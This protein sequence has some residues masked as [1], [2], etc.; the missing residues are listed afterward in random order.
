MDAEKDSSRISPERH[1]GRRELTFCLSGDDDKQKYV[2]NA[3]HRIVKKLV[4]ILDRRS[5]QTGEERNP[6]KNITAETQRAQE[7]HFL[8]VGRRDNKNI[9]PPGQ[10]LLPN[11]RLPIGQN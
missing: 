11:R 5:T 7:L 4:K 3:D 2:S 1:R 6:L 8:F 10:N 9:S